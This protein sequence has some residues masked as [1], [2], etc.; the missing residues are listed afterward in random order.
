MY[1]C[2]HSGSFIQNAHTCFP[3]VSHMIFKYTSDMNFASLNTLVDQ[4]EGLQKYK[5]VECYTGAL[6]FSCNV[7]FIPCNLTTGTPRPICSDVCANFRHT[8]TDQF[9][10][11]VDLSSITT[12]YPFIQNCENTLSHLN[13]GYG[14]P[15]LSSEFKDDCF[16]F[17]GT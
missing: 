7:L 15:N 17:S 3:Y 2:T 6:Q 10:V 1:S 9:N 11:L 12:L 5:D 4:L 8:C 14:Y 16:S 13:T